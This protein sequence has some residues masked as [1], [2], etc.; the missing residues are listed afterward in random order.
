VH[1]SKLANVVTLRCLFAPVCCRVVPWAWQT[2]EQL[3]SELDLEESLKQ[4]LC[5]ELNQLVSTSV[6]SQLERFEQLKAALEALQGGTGAMARCSSAPTQYAQAAGAGQVQTTPS[7]HQQQPAGPDTVAMAPPQNMQQRQRPQLHPQLPVSTHAGA[8]GDAQ[9]E[10][11]T[12]AAAAAEAPAS[13]SRHVQLPGRSHH[14]AAAVTADGRQADVLQQGG[15]IAQH[16]GSSGRQPGCSS[17]V[18]RD[19]EGRFAGFE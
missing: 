13:R 6:S 19:R 18:T 17:H 10:E 14:S 4:Q 5:D 3:Q 12:A 1:T 15:G 2:Y 9:A 11:T 7:Q 16:Q 8:P